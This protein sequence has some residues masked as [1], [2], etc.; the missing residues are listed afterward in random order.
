MLELWRKR[1][2]ISSMSFKH[3][4]P[5]IFAR[6]QWQRKKDPNAFYLAYRV[7][8]TT[9]LV[10]AWI[11]SMIDSDNLHEPYIFH[12]K[13]L[14]YLTNWGFT[15]CVL[16]ALVCTIML[17]ARYAK[18]RRGGLNSDPDLVPNVRLYKIYWFCF[19]ISVDLGIAI[20]LLYWIVIF[21]PDKMEI[22]YLNILVHCTNSIAMVI[23]LSVVAHPVRLG[24]FYVPVT[25]GFVY[26]LFSFFYY[27]A[28]GTSRVDE[29]YIY[30]P[31]DW[32]K[33]G[34]A[35][36]VCFGACILLMVIHVVTYGAYRL[37]LAIAKRIKLTDDEAT[38]P[39]EDQFRGFDNN[40]LANDTV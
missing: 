27:L 12:L 18:M 35:L 38:I 4:D 26:T 17:V 7:V 31:V 5:T 16:Q 2:D 37:R 30:P 6:S 9:Y 34:Q 24:H 15:C 36:L 20:T 8:I 14:I 39:V 11:L 3:E 13:W 40:C 10:I 23:E 33:P 21:N 32:R 29:P 19:T 22:D 25:S 1:L 28:G